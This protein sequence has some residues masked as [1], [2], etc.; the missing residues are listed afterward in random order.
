M[1]YYEPLNLLTL[2]RKLVPGNLRWTLQRSKIV[3]N[4]VNSARAK[5]L[6]Q[7]NKRL[8]ICSAQLAHAL[9][10][11]GIDLRG[12]TC[13]EIGTGWVLSHAVGMHLLGAKQVIATDIDHMARP[14]TLKYSIGEAV[15]YLPVDIL[16]PFEDHEQIR[17]RMD[18]LTAIDDFNFDILRTMGIEYDAPID[19]AQRPLGR[20]VDFIYSASVFEHVPVEDVPTLLNNLVHDM[21]P[22]AHMIHCIHMEDH[23]DP[24]DP[25]AFLGEPSTTYGREMQTRWGNRIRR[26]K[27]KKIFS[28]LSGTQY[29]CFYDYSNHD[30]P[31]PSNIDSAVEH[32]D[33]DDLRC[34]HLGVLVT[35]AP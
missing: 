35:K 34:T 13:L 31:L 25:F 19:L 10:L 12:K 4:F 27:W 22:G 33:E 26:N 7:T 5:R 18:R 3:S 30:K 17:R 6:A 8:D 15:Q 24:D 14:Q 28:E 1:C 29:A 21:N 20:N 11:T 16:S 2:G 23:R 32:V 9:H